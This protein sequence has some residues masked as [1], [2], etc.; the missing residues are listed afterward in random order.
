MLLI[1]VQ[2]PTI[3]DLSMLKL[4]MFITFLASFLFSPLKFVKLRF[5]LHSFVIFMP[6]ALCSSKKEE[7]QSHLGVFGQGTKSW[8]ERRRRRDKTLRE[9]TGGNAQL[10]QS[11]RADK[12]HVRFCARPEMWTQFRKYFF[13]KPFEVI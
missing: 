2:K 3:S 5:S 7:S 12:G 10:G 9:N 1:S 8:Y 4:K 6:L 11:T 13:A